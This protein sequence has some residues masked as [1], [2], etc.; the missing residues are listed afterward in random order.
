[1]EAL[2]QVSGVDLFTPDTLCRF[3]NVNMVTAF[4][5]EEDGNAKHTELHT[6]IT[7]HKISTASKSADWYEF[8]VSSWSVGLSALHCAGSIRIDAPQNVDDIAAFTNPVMVD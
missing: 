8:S 4:V 7:Q 5:F 3:Q 1:M 6:T 2:P